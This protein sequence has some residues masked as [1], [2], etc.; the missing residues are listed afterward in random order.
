MKKPKTP[1]IQKQSTLQRFFPRPRLFAL[2]HE[3][4]ITQYKPE[5]HKTEAATNS[6]LIRKKRHYLHTRS[7]QGVLYVALNEFR[8]F[9]AINLF[10]RIDYF[11]NSIIPSGEKIAEATVDDDDALTFIGIDPRLRR[12]KIGTQMIRF[13]KQRC[14]KFHVFS[15]QD[16]NSR[17]RLTAEG[18]HLIRYC[19]KQKILDDEDFISSDTPV[20]SS[21][22]AK[23]R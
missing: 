14:E 17:Y 3:S 13:M 6:Q 7:H 11:S 12:Q 4:K 22:C 8:E 20:P 15:G 16:F 23:R 18:M 5:K 1:I 2:A 19:L 10:D 21:P 9:I